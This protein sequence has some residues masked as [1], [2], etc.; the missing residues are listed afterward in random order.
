M[1]R[2]KFIS[3][4]DIQS[5]SARHRAP[6]LILNVCV[7]RILQLVFC[8]CWNIIAFGRNHDVAW[9]ALEFRV[10]Y[11]IYLLCACALV[12]TCVCLCGRKR[13]NVINAC[14]NQM[15]NL[16][17]NILQQ[18]YL[19]HIQLRQVHNN[20]ILFIIQW[21]ALFSTLP[22]QHR[23]LWIIYIRLFVTC[24]TKHVLINL[25]DAFGHTVSLIFN[26]VN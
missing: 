4:K 1:I 10:T 8:S 9:F 24:A 15:A 6:I 2:I 7:L 23:N 26:R 16:L 14:V 25:L 13:T 3:V 18:M 12:H 19:I 17:D 5:S 22:V 20:A 11:A 21:R